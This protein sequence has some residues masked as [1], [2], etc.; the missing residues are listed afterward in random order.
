[1]SANTP[2]SALS[3]NDL[4]VVLA[5]ARGG[6]LAAAARRL[7][8]NH[9][10]VFRRLGALERR[11]G[12]RLFDRLPEGYAATEPCAAIV[13]AAERIEAELHDLDRRLLGQD[14]RPQGTVRLTAPDDM[15]EHL[16]MAPLTRFAAAY[17]EITVEL[18][19]QNRL[20]DLTRREADAALRPTSA[21]PETLVGRQVATVATAVYAAR[22]SVTDRKAAALATLPWV[23]WEA[24]GGPAVSARWLGTHV[25]EARVVFRSNSMLNLLAAARH[26]LG[27]ALLPCY[28][29]D[30]TPQLVR[31]GPP[32]AELDSG[33]WLLT[34]TDLRRS[35]RVRVLLDFLYRE[36]RARAA[37]LDGTAAGGDA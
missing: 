32:L 33:L 20:F 30:A 25:P 12:E 35:A 16:L 28:L 34:H 4:R 7:G 29:G 23:A 18:A 2:E 13:A 17:P 3:G 14:R 22:H 26:G 19:L 10:T 21:P 6:T 15:A 5:V 11:L 36:L 24:G 1:M 37:D 8:V 27:A 31:L 9:S